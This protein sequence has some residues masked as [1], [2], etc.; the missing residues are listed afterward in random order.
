MK[1]FKILFSAL[2]ILNME[3]D[4]QNIPFT[5]VKS[6]YFYLF[7]ATLF[8]FKTDSCWG[9]VTLVEVTFSAVKTLLEN[10]SLDLIAVG[11]SLAHSTEF[12]PTVGGH[13]SCLEISVCA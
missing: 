13:S 3:I 8:V 9:Y 2:C 6:E 1:H 5:E 12:D 11:I 7:K 10:F 4:D